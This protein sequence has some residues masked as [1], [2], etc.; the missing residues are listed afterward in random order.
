MNFTTN[1][2]SGTDDSIYNL[3]RRQSV[4]LTIV[5]EAGLA[6]LIAVL[7]VFLIIFRNFLWRIRNVAR[8]SWHVFHTPMD[9]LMFSLFSAELLQAV[10]C[11]MSLKWIHEGVVQVGGFCLA[12]GVIKQL[13]QTGGAITTLLIT[14]YTFVGIWMGKTAT[15]MQVTSA[16]IFVAW[17]SVAAMVIIG[18]TVNGRPGEAPFI[19]P[20]PY[21]CWI[22]GSYPKWRILGEYLWIWITL[23]FAVAAYVPLWLWSRGNIVINDHQWWKFKLQHADANMDSSFRRQSILMLAY[24]LTYCLSKLPQSVVRGISFHGHGNGALTPTLSSLLLG[25]GTLVSL[26]GVFN[27]VL[28]LT[29]RS[30]SVLF[31]KQSHSSAG[32]APC[33]RELAHNSEVEYFNRESGEGD[34]SELGALPSRS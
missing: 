20:V 23:S 29:T 25:F 33:H 6:S 31:Q 10:G 19:T 22:H 28:L 8:E 11:V 24:P 27:V 30:E 15:S 21:W 17:L 4:G 1:T 32:R 7:Y 34:D 18:N 26:S 2:L 3:T 14:L 16:V 12:Q 13:G 9:L 5:V